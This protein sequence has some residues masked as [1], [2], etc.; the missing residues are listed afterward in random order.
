[1]KNKHHPKNS[2]SQT[3]TQVPSRRPHSIH[4]RVQPHQ[5]LRAHQIPLAHELRNVQIQRTVRFTASTQK[6]LH[7]FQ[8]ADDAV[9]GRPGRLEQVEA[10]L[11]GG[12][13]DVGVAAGR[14]EGYLRRR[15]GVCLGDGEG[16]GE[17]AACV[18][19]GWV[20]S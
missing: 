9:R 2:R 16:E 6:L 19:E 3:P 18:R 10:D 13:G 17:D 14:L 11:A 8:R 7:G 1:M 20:V 4:P 5:S 15:V 12:E